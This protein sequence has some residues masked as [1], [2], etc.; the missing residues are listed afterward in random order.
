MTTV[1]REVCCVLWVAKFNAV[2]LVQH[3]YRNVFHE[4]ALHENN[5]CRWDKQVK[6][7]GSLLK[8]NI[9]IGHPSAMKL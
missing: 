8:K 4:G 7:T 2:I 9:Q 1:Q 3:E 5:I 6:E